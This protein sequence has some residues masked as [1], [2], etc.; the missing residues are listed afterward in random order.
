MEAQQE[1]FHSVSNKID[2]RSERDWLDALFT[3]FFYAW[4]DYQ[5]RYAE[6]KVVVGFASMLALVEDSVR[7]FSRVYPDGFLV[8]I[9]RE[10]IGW[11]ASVKQRRLDR[12]AGGQIMDVHGLR[13][14]ASFEDAEKSYLA[15]VDAMLRNSEL[16]GE[17]FALVHYSDLAGQTEIS[18]RRLCGRIG[19]D[20]H[21][22]LVKQTFNGMRITPN[23]S[24]RGGS[25]N[26]RAHILT[27]AETRQIR[28]GAMM[29]AYQRVLS[30]LGRPVA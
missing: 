6:K 16:L 14:Y 22:N 8:S 2:A 18:M 5:S 10:P 12:T 7:S 1:L 13:P 3:S 21:S 27:D 29:D 25:K 15:N 30:Q 19:L 9:L 24:F 11:Y 17:R 26:N 20:W 4:L 28:D 23:S